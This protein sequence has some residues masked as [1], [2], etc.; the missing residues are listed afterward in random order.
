MLKRKATGIRSGFTLVELLVVI[1]IIGILV[2][3]LLPAVQQAREAARRMS[4]QNNLKQIALAAHNFESAYKRLPAGSIYDPRLGG[5]AAPSTAYTDNLTHHTFVG[6]LVFLLPFVE[7][8]AIYQPFASNL[9]M[10]ANGF[11]DSVMTPVNPRKLP[12]WNYAAINAVT[13]VP[14]PTF[15]CPSD[16]ADLGRKLNSADPSLWYICSPAG[17]STLGLYMSDLAGDPIVRNH[18][19]TNYLGVAG[20]MNVKAD[21]IGFASGTWQNREID[22]YIGVFQFD[23]EAQFRDITDGLSNTAMFGEVTG[24]FTNG[25]RGTGRLRSFTWTANAQPM[26][27]MGYILADTSVTPNPTEYDSTDRNMTRFSSMHTGGIISYAFCDG[28][29]KPMNLAT[30]RNTLYRYA[31]R[32]DGLTIVNPVE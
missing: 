24:D 9:Q 3:L 25:R 22:Q 30:D 20:R 18:R 7:Q 6:H 31:G 14:I 21:W 19:C 1:A 13:S 27:W 4:C 5:P 29:V 23:E 32:A 2:G 12:Y 16:N 15:L 28:S 26:H 8:Q 10:T 11:R 17:P